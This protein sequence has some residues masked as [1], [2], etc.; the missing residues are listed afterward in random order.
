VEQV[1]SL[2][3]EDGSQLIGRRLAR[4]DAV[5]GDPARG[6]LVVEDR[7]DPDASV[8]QARV[9]LR[10]VPEDPVASTVEGA[11]PK[12]PMGDDRDLDAEI[13]ESGGQALREDLGAADR[14]GQSRDHD[15]PHGVDPF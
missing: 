4:F 11:R 7:M 1:R 14:L 9:V 12:D 8:Q 2:L 5:G 13:I 3:L 6:A 15:D 10:A